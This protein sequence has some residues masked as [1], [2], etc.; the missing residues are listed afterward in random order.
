MDKTESLLQSLKN[1][2]SRIHL[3]L[4]SKRQE[5]YHSQQTTNKHLKIS[6][7]LQELID[8]LV[9]DVSQTN[10]NINR[11]VVKTDTS[12]RT[13]Q[14]TKNNNANDDKKEKTLF[15]E[16]NLATY[17]KNH[18]HQ[19]KHPSIAAQLRR[20]I[21]EHVHAAHR[22]ARTGEKESALFHIDIASNAL[23][24]LEHYMPADEY[25]QLVTIIYSQLSE[26]EMTHIPPKQFTI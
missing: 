7:T 12:I 6:D 9:K 18:K 11:H 25:D 20:R 8:D 21:W 14:T 10:T 5:H 26:D 19:E 4:I 1:L 22:I 23:Q 16:D 13:S 17:F 3:H 24:T 15:I 2:Y